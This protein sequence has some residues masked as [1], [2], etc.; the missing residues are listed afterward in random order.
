MPSSTLTSKGQT[1][2]PKT[3]RDR[4]GVTAGDRVDFIVHPDGRITLEPALQGVVRL[5]G[6]LAGRRRRKPVSV[7]TMHAAVRR[8]AAAAR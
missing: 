6:L 1:T 4:L 3:I 2:I 8:R 5:K 7:E